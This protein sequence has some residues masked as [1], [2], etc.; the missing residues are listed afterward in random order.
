[1]EIVPKGDDST[2]GLEG[3]TMTRFKLAA[4]IALAVVLGMFGTSK[5]RRRYLDRH[6]AFALQNATLSGGAAA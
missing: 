3:Q 2:S 4:P 5:A 1:M 6:C